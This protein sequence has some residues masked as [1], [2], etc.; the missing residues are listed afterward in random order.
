MNNILISD[1]YKSSHFKFYPPE[2]TGI[3]SYLE[4]R[5]GLYKDIVF[6]G[7]QGFIKDY[8]LTPITHAN[9]DEA[10][11]FGK[12]HGVPFDEVGFRKIVDKHNGYFPVIIKAVKEGKV[13][14]YRNALVTVESIDPELP[15]VAS[16]I[17]TMLLRAL[18]YPCTIAS[19]S[20]F[21][22]QQIDAFYNKYASNGANADFALLDFSSRGCSS[23]ET[24]KIGAAAF[25]TSFIGSDSIPGVHWANTRYNCEMS[26]FSV[27]ATE[28]SV[29]T[30]YGKD[31]EFASFKRLIEISEPG[32]IISVVSDTW[33][34]FNACKYW[35]KLV[36][37]I[38]KKGLQ[39][40]VRPDS[41]DPK[42][43]LPKMYAILEKG[44]ETY[45]NDKGLKLFKNLKL[46]WGDGI[47]EK[48]FM[49]VL[50]IPVAHGFSPETLMLGSGGGLLQNVTRDDCKWAFKASAVYKK[51]QWVPIKKDP[52]TDPGKQS[53]AGKLELI[54]HK[55]KK[56]FGTVD[57]TLAKQLG[58]PMLETVYENGKLVRDQTI[59]EIR[60]LIETNK[61]IS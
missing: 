25:L 41:G 57:W 12:L 29:M 47:S 18:W 22:R 9:V 36:P 30:A 14:P 58:Q 5:G 60:N 11:A 53:K 46:L 61:V 3:F 51:G 31:N 33:D 59:S 35:N 49:E 20:Y 2:V 15:W 37:E 4:S 13:I 34:V 10:V 52:I 50:N 7:L 39:L 26:G 54:F 24:N 21:M 42:E 6:F 16:Y 27:P 38:Y 32:S 45:V 1:S 48:T 44:F 23:L 43:V 56:E 19:K 40:V 17:E 8:L 28:H 55:K